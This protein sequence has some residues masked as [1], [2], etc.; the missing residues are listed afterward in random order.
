MSPL[1]WP[2]RLQVTVEIILAN[3]LAHVIRLNTFDWTD[4]Q[5]DEL[6]WPRSAKVP[7]IT[8]PELYE[9]ISEKSS[10]RCP[11][12]E[13]NRILHTDC[14]RLP[15]PVTSHLVGHVDQPLESPLEVCLRNGHTG[16]AWG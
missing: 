1:R 15:L 5:T 13:F 14:P 9:L 3:G 8:Y 4:D 7:A 11:R 6:N 16:L 12:D 2:R 10:P